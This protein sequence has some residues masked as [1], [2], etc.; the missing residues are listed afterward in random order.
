MSRSCIH[1]GRYPPLTVA[2]DGSR[3]LS[4]ALLATSQPRLRSRR[5]ADTCAESLGSIQLLPRLELICVAHATPGSTSAWG[6][7]SI[8]TRPPATMTLIWGGSSGPVGLPYHG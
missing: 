6:F 2:C 3:R 5:Q 4:V 8:A 1:I 7:H